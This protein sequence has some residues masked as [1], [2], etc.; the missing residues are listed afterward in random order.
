MGHSALSPLVARAEGPLTHALKSI[1]GGVYAR[2]GRVGAVGRLQ[3]TIDMHA[4]RLA[5]RGDRGHVDVR[6]REAVFVNAVTVEHVR[7]DVAYD[8]SSALATCLAVPG[9]NVDR[10]RP[11]FSEKGEKE[12]IAGKS[13]MSLHDFTHGGEYL[14]YELKSS[15]PPRGAA[16]R[17]DGVARV[18]AR[19]RGG[20]RS[21][22]A[23]CRT[24]A[25]TSSTVLYAERRALPRALRT[26]KPS[27]TRSPSRT[28]ARAGSRR[29]SSTRGRRLYSPRRASR[30]VERGTSCTR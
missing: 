6:L 8:L 14:R 4:K 2:F 21:R 15:T 24:A 22:T 25:T 17:L 18:P 10:N 27:A 16:R 28:A 11:A 29:A 5:L 23:R 13:A 30:R 7:G 19:A 12:R 3:R 9:W 1:R 26:A 20:R